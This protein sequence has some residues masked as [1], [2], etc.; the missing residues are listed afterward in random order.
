MLR[1][2]QFLGR[3]LVCATAVG[4]LGTSS[5]TYAQDANTWQSVRKAGVL[6][7]GVATSPPYTMKDPLTGNYSGV[8]PE[9]CRDFAEKVLKVKVEYVDTTWDNI[10]AGL[11]SDKWD[12]SLSLNDTPE[13][14]KAISFTE[15]VIDYS[16]TLAYNKNNPKVPKSIHS[17]ADIDKP[18][19][20][21]TVMS[22]TVQDKAITGALK[23]A[24]IM[25]LP[26]FDETRLALQ[27]KR[28]DMLADDSMTNLLLTRA[29]PDWAD[30][31]KPTPPLAP[32]G[33]NFGI[34]K[35][36]PSAD[37]AVFNQFIAQQKQAG[38]VNAYLDRS[39]KET[40]AQTK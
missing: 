1:I 22:G 26:G 4:A 9:L 23:Q 29:H 3:A 30:A 7:C 16:V 5:T 2:S 14:R 40:I 15:P 34:R 6:R 10:V 37:I 31:F 25:R 38:T 18:G 28:A 27:S 24:T 11:Q 13:R 8:F 19:M 35:D 36:T 17:V 39:V 21:V 12:V 32:Q 20:I 33:I